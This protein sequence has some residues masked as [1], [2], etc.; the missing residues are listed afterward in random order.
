MHYLQIKT[1]IMGMTQFDENID[2][3]KTTGGLTNQR[4]WDQ[5]P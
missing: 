2:H 1:V 3:D 5:V 4:L